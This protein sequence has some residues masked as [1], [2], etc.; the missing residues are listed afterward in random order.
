[1]NEE[2]PGAP[3]DE[4]PTDE[5]PATNLNDAA[6]PVDGSADALVSLVERGAGIDLG[7][8]V[9]P[10]DASTPVDAERATLLTRDAGDLV[11]GLA[12]CVTD[13]GALVAVLP[14]VDA[15]VVRTVQSDARPAVSCADV[16]VV[17][18]G[19]A[20]ARIS[21]PGGTAI[22]AALT[23]RSIDW[24]VSAASAPV[25]FLIVD[26]HAA[27]CGFD[28]GRLETALV[29]TNDAIRS[30]V[31]ETCRRYLEAAEPGA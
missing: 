20:R 3:T 13:A 19:P 30:W 14:H 24:Y 11:D 17:F 5:G 6:P 2:P 12:T 29:S 26:E 31:A 16:R 23:M 25:G 28:H 15:T 10:D 18:V 9:L 1:M 4:A 8:V 7:D 27:V 21:G 22:R